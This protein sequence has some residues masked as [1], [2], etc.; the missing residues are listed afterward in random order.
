MDQIAEPG[1]RHG[2]YSYREASRLLGVTS[3]RVSRW[4]DGYQFQRK[5]DRGESA[6]VLQTVRH[7]GV[8]SF[9]EL[10]ELMFVKEYIA[11]GVSLT[12]VRATAEVLAKQVGQYPFSTSKIMVQGRQLLVH[13]SEG[14]LKRPDVGQL[15]ADFAEDL[16]E[17][18]DLRQDR[19][20][21]YSVPEFDKIIYLDQER[22]GGEPVATERAIPT[23]MIFDLWEKERDIRSV[24]EYFEL[25]DGEVSAAVRYEGQ[26]RIAA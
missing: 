11:L 19:V 23:R 25:T 14:L 20:G 17:H 1:L 5:Y 16:A 10:W 3:Q 8:L 22:R 18:V 12:Q 7:Q 2:I 15:V 26:W 13:T 6:P 24:G 21:R 9:P 4:E